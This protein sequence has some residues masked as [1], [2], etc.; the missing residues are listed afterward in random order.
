MIVQADASHIDA[1]Y[2]I[3][4]R[5]RSDLGNR[6]ILQ[7][8]ASYPTR[9]VVA[10]D[11]ERGTL[12]VLIDETRLDG[13]VTLDEHQPPEYATVSWNFSEPALVVHR[14]CVDPAAQGKGV[15]KQLMDFAESLAAERG[16]A[17]VRLDAYTA[18][19]QAVGLYLRR[20]Y[21]EAGQ[22]YFA[23]RSLPFYCFELDL[24]TRA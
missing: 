4:D 22:V 23:R 8:E 24:S 14:L 15:G 6:G 9:D 13:V 11:V 21:R 1:A 17:S 2:D 12:Y 18:N 5:C 19:P 10:R 20:G 7:W 16:Y 3:I